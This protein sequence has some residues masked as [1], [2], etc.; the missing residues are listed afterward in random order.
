[1]DR[2]ATPS[3]P[4][5]PAEILATPGQRIV[6]AHRGSSAKAPENSVAA[7]QLALVDGAD[8]VE[9]DVR[10][11]GDGV[12]VIIHDATTGR[13]CNEDLEVAATDHGR[14]TALDAGTRSSMS[15]GTERGIPTLADVLE[16]FPSV[17]ILLELKTAAGQTEVRRILDHYGAQEH[18]MVASSI[19]AALRSFQDGVY[20]RAASRRE[21][22]WWYFAS[23]AGR[24]PHGPGYQ[25]ISIPPRSGV[26]A[27]TGRR[28][29]STAAR[30]GLPIHVWTVDDPV[31]AQWLWQQG[32]TG[33]ITNAPD[34]LV[35]LRDA[36][37]HDDR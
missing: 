20:R 23:L 29:L 16:R 24:R 10:V 2:S 26:L 36:A 14:L 28:P 22:G 35:A 25:A 4:S 15:E 3:I 13:T 37:D 7:M 17:P 19:H 18:V 27:L 30:A 33:I 21:I 1:M 5:C 34:R 6:I 11:A 32:V 8:A 12:P 31:Q 9:M